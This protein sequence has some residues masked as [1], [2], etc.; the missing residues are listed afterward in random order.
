MEG[1]LSL[2]S[3][4]TRVGITLATALMLGANAYGHAFEVEL[5]GTLRDIWF[6]PL[7]GIVLGLAVGAV[8]LVYRWWALLP[9]LAPVAVTIY[10]HHLTDYVYP[11]HEDFYAGL[12]DRPLLLI[13]FLIVQVAVYAALLS[14]GLLLRAGWEWIRSRRREESAFSPG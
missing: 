3:N 2:M 5:H 1:Y 10:L 9:A 14:V 8:F 11:W 4:C 6:G 7:E 12:T 13:L